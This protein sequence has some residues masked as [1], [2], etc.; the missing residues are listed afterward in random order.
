LPTPPPVEDPKQVIY[1]DPQ[2]PKVIDP[3]TYPE[4]PASP[5]VITKQP[6]YGNVTVN[7]NGSITYTPTVVDNPTPV[8]DVIEFKY[9][10]LAGQ[11][12][13]VRKEIV[14]TQKGD[15]PSI[16]QTGGE[17]STSNNP[18]VFIFVSLLAA[19]FIRKGVVR[20]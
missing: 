12:I 9:T 1:V 4:P 7:N 6:E 5:V 20:G 11:T 10:N 2:T 16:I 3:T 15:V 14:L 18:F 13:V 19:A 8:V 17:D